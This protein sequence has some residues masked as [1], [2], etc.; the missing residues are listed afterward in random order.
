VGRTGKLKTTS[1]CMSEY[2]TEITSDLRLVLLGNIGCG[3]TSSGDTILGQV[4]PVSSVTTRSCTLRQGY[5]DGRSVTLVEAPRWYWNEQTPDEVQAQVFSCVALSSPG[6][7]A[8]LLCVPVD[9][10][11]KTELQAVSALEKVFGPESVQRHTLVLF[12]YADRLKASGKAENVEEYIASERSDLLKLV[13]KCGDKFHIL[14]KGEGWREK[15][16]VAELLEKVEQMVKAAGGQCY[17][18]PAFQEAE[19]KVRQR[20]LQLVRERRSNRPETIQ[21][22]YGGQFH[23][24]RQLLPLVEEDISLD[25]G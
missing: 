5:S 16:T 1:D 12:T 2:L 21:A 7:H 22:G 20:Q 13:E 17:S 14:E 18:C 24:E 8:F 4:S 19:D 6:P 3:K 10:S 15:K 9:Q 11:A 23:S 25:D